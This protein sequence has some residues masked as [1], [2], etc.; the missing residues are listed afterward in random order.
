MA[1]SFCA[2]ACALEA[3]YTN[4][5]TTKVDTFDLASSLVFLI[6]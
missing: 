2:L 3:S 6:I 5:I 4:G 1:S